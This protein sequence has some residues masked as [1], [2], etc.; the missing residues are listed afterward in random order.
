MI[1]TTKAAPIQ[2]KVEVAHLREK[3]FIIPPPQK[4]EVPESY[5]TAV[6][7][8]APLEYFTIGGIAFEKAVM[9]EQASVVRMNKDQRFF[10][11]LVC[12]LLTKSQADA[13]WAEA[14][15]RTKNIPVLRNPEYDPSQNNPGKQYIKGGTYKLS[16]FMIL[17]TE[18]GFDQKKYPDFNTPWKIEEAEATPDEV[19]AQLLLQQR[20][21]SSQGKKK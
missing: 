18:K 8:N 7:A 3:A 4:D 14:A 17:E 13:I 9:P 16:D 19:K 6:K 20:T 11:R 2:Q 21:E 1:G 10:P 12:K 15:R 5:I